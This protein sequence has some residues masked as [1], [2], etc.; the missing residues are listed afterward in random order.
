MSLELMFTCY[1][2][3][4]A[5]MAHIYVHIHIHGYIYVCDI[6]KRMKISIL[7]VCMHIAYV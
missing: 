6:D 5:D 3:I 4:Q 7:S 1:L 2:C